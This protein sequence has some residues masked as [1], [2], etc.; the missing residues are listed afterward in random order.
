LWNLYALDH[1]DE[2]LY[3]KLGKVLMENYDKLSDIDVAN[4]LRAFS[5]F[6]HTQTE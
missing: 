2:R 3:D 1:Y 4:A 5:H 6:K